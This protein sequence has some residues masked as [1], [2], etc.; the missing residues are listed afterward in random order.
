MFITSAPE[1]LCKPGKQQYQ[2]D[3]LGAW[4]LSKLSMTVLEHTSLGTPPVTLHNH[5]ILFQKLSWGSLIHILYLGTPDIMGETTATEATHLDSNPS[6][7]V[8]GCV[9]W[10]K[11][12]S[13]LQTTRRMTMELLSEGSCGD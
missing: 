1:L 7:P 10:G 3:W 9:M 11:G 5:F 6:S 4:F 12:T 2:P 8:T 13:L